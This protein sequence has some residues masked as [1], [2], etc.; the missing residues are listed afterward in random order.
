MKVAHQMPYRNP[1]LALDNLYNEWLEM[2]ISD[3]FATN[4]SLR[5]QSFTRDS[6]VFPVN[7]TFSGCDLPSN[8]PD[9]WA[10]QKSQDLNCNTSPLIT[11]LTD[12]DGIC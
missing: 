6:I 1:G 7:V 11:A 10:A 4:E 5:E 12:L 2:E 8:S 9:S 3:L